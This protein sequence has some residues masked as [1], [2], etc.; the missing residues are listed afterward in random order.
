LEGVE[1]RGAFGV[2]V[3]FGDDFRVSSRRGGGGEKGG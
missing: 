3:F 2:E 1:K